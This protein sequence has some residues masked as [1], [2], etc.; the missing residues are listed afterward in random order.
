MEESGYR[1][2]RDQYFEDGSPYRLNYT[3]LGKN[4]Q[5]RKQEFSKLLK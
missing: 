1:R 5:L 4:K 2:N 3:D